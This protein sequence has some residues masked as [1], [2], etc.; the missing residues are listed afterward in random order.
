[1]IVA[2]LPAHADMSEAQLQ[3]EL[4]VWERALRN[5]GWGK[6]VRDLLK[7]HDACADELARR[8]QGGAA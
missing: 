3:I 4:A 6:I 8:Q 2:P 7:W 1:M 5:P